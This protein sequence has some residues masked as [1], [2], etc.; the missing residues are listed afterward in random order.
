MILILNH[1]ANLNFKE[2]KEYE[3]KL[4]KYNVII[5][6]SMCYLSLFQKGKYKLASQDISAYNNNNITGEINGK[7]LKSLNI[8][9]SLVGHSDRRVYINENNDDIKNKINECLN[10]NIIPL[11]CIGE[12]SENTKEKELKE[13]IDVYLSEIKNNKIYIVYEPVNNIGSKNPNLKD[14]EKNI[15][16][17]KEHINTKRNL[18]V[19]II[20]GGGINTNNIKDI[21]NIKGIDGLIIST[22]SLSFENFKKIY[23]ETNK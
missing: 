2:I 12:F 14:I 1:K 5:M 20:Y 4:R 10:N 15:T 6:P 21:L 17:I 3:K 9:Y 19:K 8:K 13:Q 23:K 7:Q 11:C 16:F 18:N 22:D